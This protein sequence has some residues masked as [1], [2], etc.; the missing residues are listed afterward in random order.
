[1]RY[2]GIDYGTKRIGIALS[3]EGLTLA[4]PEAVL[5]NDEDILDEVQKI[6]VDKGVERIV[7]GESKNFAQEDNAI[8]PAVR[9][10]MADLKV[11]TGKEIV[12]EP[13]F[14]TSQQAE[15]FQGKTNKTDS[16]AAAIILQSY[17]DREK[18]K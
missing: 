18:N 3:D 1:M 16:S 12:L 10:F 17:L 7:L 6:V 9:Q 8:M 11:V 13:E 5:P 2:M 15:Y 4:F 14:L